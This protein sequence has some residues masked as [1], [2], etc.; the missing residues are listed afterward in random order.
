[1]H[2]MVILLVKSESKDIAKGQILDVVDNFLEYYVDDV[3]DWY[4]IGG[5]WTGILSPYFKEF[6]KKSK[7]IL[8]LNTFGNIS[9][10]EVE[11][12]QEQ[13][14]EIWENLGGK[15]KNPYANHYELSI[16][17]GIYDVMKLSDCIEIVKELQIHNKDIK[18]Q[19]FCFECAV[20]NLETFDYLIPE[21]IED[22]YAVVVDLHN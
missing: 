10:N 21:N 4:Q 6:E 22:Y 18:T 13:L 2:S 19:E 12:K 7:N 20:Y 3:F 11:N 8:K 17:G 5:R 16:E 9:C 14:Q 1:M 15:G